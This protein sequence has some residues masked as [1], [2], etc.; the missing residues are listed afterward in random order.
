MTIGETLIWEATNG[1]LLIP[2]SDCV[3]D[4]DSYGYDADRFSPNGTGFFS[5]AKQGKEFTR[6]AS[7]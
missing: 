1:L 5:S 7:G 3:G 4:S 2:V 6:F